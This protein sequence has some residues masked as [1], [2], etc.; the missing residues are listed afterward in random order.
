ML[1]DL[2]R[3]DPDEFLDLVSEIIHTSQENDVMMNVSGPLQMLL[4]TEPYRIVE[5]VEVLAAR[6][7][8]F[9]ALLRWFIPSEPHNEV[10][11]RVRRAAGEVPW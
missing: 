3:S 11:S 2:S 7:P 9:R 6:D 1:N 4:E 10:W 8:A 5:K